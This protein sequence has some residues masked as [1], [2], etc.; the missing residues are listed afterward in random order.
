MNV[1]QTINVNTRWQSR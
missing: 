1:Y